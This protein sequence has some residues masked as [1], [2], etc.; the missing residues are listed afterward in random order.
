MELNLCWMVSDEGKGKG[1]ALEGKGE[2][3]V[4]EQRH[5]SFLFPLL[6]CTP[7][8]DEVLVLDL[9][10]CGKYG[11]KKTKLSAHSNI[12]GFSMI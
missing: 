5:R 3:G 12:V 1:R 2:E 11:R 7:I 8:Q 10:K 4:G 9:S 6:P